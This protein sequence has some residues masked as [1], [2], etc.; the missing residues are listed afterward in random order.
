[1]SHTKTGTH[2]ERDRATTMHTTTTRRVPPS[3][4]VLA[5]ALLLACA[6][7]AHASEGMVDAAASPAAKDAAQDATPISA[8]PQQAQALPEPQMVAQPSFVLKGVAFD[9]ATGVPESE[10]QAAVA[11][12]IGSNVTFADLE[13]L[14][15]R[16]VVLYQ[17][18]GFGLVQAFVPVQEVVDG[19]VRI[20][21]SEGVLGNVSIV[22]A[23]GTPVEQARVA[24]TL[25]I[26][27]PGKPLNGRNYERA[28]LLLSDLPG[29][30]PQSAIS[31]GALAGTTDLTVQVGKRERMQPALGQPVRTWRQ[32]GPADDGGPRRAYRVRADLL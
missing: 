8:P 11:D 22:L 32:P 25:A 3:M 14:A 27:E 28:M 5:T 13:Q 29:I 15:A 16:V 19:Q 4:T 10:L 23:D 7:L 20:T 21:V 18:R 30:K 1:M 12:K 6:S 17:Q 24:G 9:G 2:L 26:L 31:T